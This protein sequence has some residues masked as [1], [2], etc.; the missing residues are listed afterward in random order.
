MFADLQSELLFQGR[1]GSLLASA[2]GLPVPDLLIPGVWEDD[3]VQLCLAF[4]T[5]WQV[6]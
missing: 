2:H 5:P 3:G 4:W 6:F 1:D